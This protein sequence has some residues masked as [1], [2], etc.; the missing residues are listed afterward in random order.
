MQLEFE[1][2]KVNTTISTVIIELGM[3]VSLFSV[4]PLQK[5]LIENKNE[6]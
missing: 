6:F 2:E 1:E 4:I 5:K 3:A